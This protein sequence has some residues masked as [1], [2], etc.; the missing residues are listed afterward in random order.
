MNQDEADRTLSEDD[1]DTK[2]GPEAR[3]DGSLLREHEEV[4]G[5]DTN[6]VWTVIEGDEGTLYAMAGYH[7]VNRVGYLVTREP[8]T[9]PDTMAVYSVPV[10]FDAAA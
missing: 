10:D 4:R 5:V 1:F 2:F 6:R 8:W 7:V 9:D 3:A